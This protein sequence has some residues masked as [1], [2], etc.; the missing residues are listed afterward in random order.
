MATNKK[1]QHKLRNDIIL[2]LVILAAAMCVWRVWESKKNIGTYAV[3]LV[4]GEETMRLPLEQDKTI[5]LER[6]DGG[7]NILEIQNGVADITD[8][9]CPDHI[10]V[11]SHGISNVGETITCLPNK[12]VIQIVDN[13]G[14]ASNVDVIS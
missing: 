4:E 3:V 9:S 1:G 6:D 7:Y 12:T 13:D 11:D 2:I 8:A 5:R 10:C 14:D